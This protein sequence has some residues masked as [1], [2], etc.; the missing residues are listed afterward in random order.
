MGILGE[1]GD[2]DIPPISVLLAKQHHIDKI[3]LIICN[4]LK[5]K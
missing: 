5:S 1:S 2:G 3:D 4:L